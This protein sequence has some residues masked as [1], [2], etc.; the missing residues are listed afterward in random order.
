MKNIN[1]EKRVAQLY[2]YLLPVRMISFFSPL[3]SI[4]HGAAL[5]LDFIINII[6]I[7]LCVVEYRGK[8]RIKKDRS[9]LVQ[10]GLL[11]LV[12]YL[13]ISS[14]IMAFFTQIKYGDYAGKES[15]FSGIT[16]MVI[17]FFQYFIMFWY[18]SHVFELITKQ[19]LER[20]FMRITN[21][22]II[23]GYFQIAVHLL[24]G[25]LF[26]FQKR[27]DILGILYINERAKGISLLASEP[28]EAGGQIMLLCVA[29]IYAKILLEQNTRKNLY[30]I[31]LFLPIIYFT[32]SSTTYLEFLVCTIVFLFLYCKLHGRKKSFVIG[33]SIVIM[34]VIVSIINPSIYTKFMPEEFRTNIQY[35]LFEKMLDRNNGST[36]S[37]TVPFF[38]NWGAFKESPI[39]GVGNGL[40]GYYYTKYFP[41]WGFNISG[42]DILEYY[43]KAQYSIVNGAL[44]IPS[45]I[46]GYGLVG[47]SLILI[48]FKRLVNLAKYGK[49][50]MGIFYYM[51]I[52][53]I[54]VFIV[55]G[56]QSEICG[57][58]Y[59]WFM[60]SLP[61]MV[62]SRTKIKGRE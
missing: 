19:E 46:S 15:A 56:M 16:G 24:G 2:V 6:G 9:G 25:W 45:L 38:T 33:L 1:L 28:A 29:Y 17:Y 62:K 26:S 20:I 27:L 11:K 58:Y 47:I 44:F 30:K 42:S 50:Q 14:L 54:F 22:M 55:I 57:C 5:Y 34:F 43:S 13:N 10:L 36:A 49:K 32:K 23:L 61:L 4:M 37:R 59:I 8:V 7:I 12:I 3:V 35:I 40:Q 53:S 21:G 48:W 31:I 18:N 60:L 39:L 41:S 52:M 51:F